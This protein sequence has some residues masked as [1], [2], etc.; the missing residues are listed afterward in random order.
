VNRGVPFM[1]E[2]KSQPVGKGILSLAEAVRARLSVLEA[3]G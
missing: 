1:L 3:E 2:G